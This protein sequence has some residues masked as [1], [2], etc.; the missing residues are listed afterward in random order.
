M[1][2]PGKGMPED[3]GKLNHY[4]LAIMLERSKNLDDQLSMRNRPQGGVG[5]YFVFMPDCLKQQ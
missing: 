1:G 3:P 4:G 5:I 2:I